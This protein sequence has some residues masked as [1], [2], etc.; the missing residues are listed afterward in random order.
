[1]KNLDYND[2]VVL[3]KSFV[4]EYTNLQSDPKLICSLGWESQT[5]IS[6]L[7]HIMINDIV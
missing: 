2:F 6:E 7:A 4:P 5:N 3:E 1:M